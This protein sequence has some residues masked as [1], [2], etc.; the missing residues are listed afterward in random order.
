[1]ATARRVKDETEKVIWIDARG[2]ETEYR[3][4]Y[5]HDG[6]LLDFASVCSNHRTGSIDYRNCRKAAKQWF[7]SKCNGGSAAGKMYCHARNAFRPG[8]GG[9]GDE[10]EFDPDDSYAM[11][12]T[13]GAWAGIAQHRHLGRPGSI[14]ASGAPAG[15]KSEFRLRKQ[16]RRSPAPGSSRRLPWLSSYRRT[17]A[18]SPRRH[19]P[20]RWGHPRP[21]RCRSRHP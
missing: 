7:G 9:S 2:D 1:P 8:G 3:M 20:G 14:P 5:E 11:A 17:S 4:Y 18:P 21:G 15:L 19:R 16:P 6:T 12:A 10:M 13:L